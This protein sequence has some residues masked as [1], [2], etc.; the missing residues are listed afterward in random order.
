MPSN[1][2]LP[3]S[4]LVPLGALIVLARRARCT[5]DPADQRDQPYQ[6]VICMNRS[7]G[8]LRRAKRLSAALRV[9]DYFA[10]RSHVRGDL[11]MNLNFQGSDQG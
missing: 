11:R 6:S 4:A 1:E 8:D 7:R 5:W 2:A 10:R 3:L 9:T